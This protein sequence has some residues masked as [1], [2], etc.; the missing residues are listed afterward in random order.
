M[1]GYF[2]EI[3]PH[4][5]KPHI[6][7]ADWAAGGIRFRVLTWVPEEDGRAPAH[8]PRVL[9]PRLLEPRLQGANVLYACHIPR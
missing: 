1:V 4:A 5:S 9:D 3:R 8:G 2:A 6:T 7:K